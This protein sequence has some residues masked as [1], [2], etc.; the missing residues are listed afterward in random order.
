MSLRMLAASLLV[1][2]GPAWLPSV[3]GQQDPLSRVKEACP[4]Y[5]QYAA[6]PQY[7]PFSPSSDDDELS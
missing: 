4:D 5:A 3:A 7:G 1:A 2:F 6:Y